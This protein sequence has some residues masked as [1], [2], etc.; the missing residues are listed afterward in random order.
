MAGNA[1]DPRIVSDTTLAQFKTVGLKP[2]RPVPMDSQE[3]NPT[4]VRMMGFGLPFANFKF[5]NLESTA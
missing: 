2:L 3:G 1:A 5:E 4:L